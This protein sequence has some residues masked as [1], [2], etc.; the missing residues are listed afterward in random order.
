MHNKIQE[1]IFLI[2]FYR[3]KNYTNQMYI[4]FDWHKSIEDHPKRLISWSLDFMWLEH[5]Q[6][7]S[8]TV[9][10]INF[11][12]ESIFMSYSEINRFYFYHN[13]IHWAEHKRGF[14]I[15]LYAILSMLFSFFRLH[16]EHMYS[17][18][19][20]CGISLNFELTISRST[21]NIIKTLIISKA[22]ASIFIIS[23][24]KF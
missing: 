2:W 14:S 20:E 11:S 9:F 5:A 7:H 12:I 16:C 3:L 13:Y 6:C 23:L 1:N 15:V 8:N 21:C 22:Y 17:L 24:F 10:L 4:I 18:S 19:I